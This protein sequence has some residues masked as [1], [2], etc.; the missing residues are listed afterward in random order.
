[1]KTIRN[2]EADETVVEGSGNVF[3]DL[4]LPD[5]AGELAK[6]RLKLDAAQRGRDEIVTP[7]ARLG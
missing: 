1:M 4:G 3:A 5:A 7:S 6:A 2:A